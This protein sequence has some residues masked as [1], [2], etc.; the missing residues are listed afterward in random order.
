MHGSRW[1]TGDLD[2]LRLRTVRIKSVCSRMEA[3]WFE[4]DTAR[5]RTCFSCRGRREDGEGVSLVVESEARSVD[6]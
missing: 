2:G 1:I 6:V 4:Y 3:E 5:R